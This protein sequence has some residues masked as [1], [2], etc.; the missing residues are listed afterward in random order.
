MQ[1]QERDFQ[2]RTSSE[3]QNEILSPSALEYIVAAWEKNVCA[4]ASGHTILE[5]VLRKS[6]LGGQLVIVLEMVEKVA[7]FQSSISGL[8]VRFTPKQ[9]RAT[10]CGQALSF[11]LENVILEASNSGR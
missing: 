10:I 6:C 7:W 1:V 8:A 11:L 2:G 3:I 4:L 9:S 5:K